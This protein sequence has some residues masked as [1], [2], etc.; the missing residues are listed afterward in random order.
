MSAVMSDLQQTARSMR[1]GRG[2]LA[3]AVVTMALGITAATLMF[4]LVS[5]VLL[6]PLPFRDPDKLVMVWTHLPQLPLGFDAYPVHGRQYRALREGSTGQLSGIDAFKA[7]LFNLSTKD[8]RVERIDGLVT[9]AGLFDTLGVHP[10]AGRF[11]QAGEDAP[12]GGHVAVIGFG[13]WARAFGA[14]PAAIGSVVRLNDE[15]FTIVGVA[16][17]GFDFPRGGEM[18]GN[19]QFPARTELWVAARPPETGPAEH[20][21]V[22]RMRTGVS[23]PQA[24][25]A[26]NAATRALEA[27]MPGARGWFGVQVVPMARQ[28]VPAIARTIVAMLFAAATI[29]VLIGCANAAQLLV[30]RGLRRR[31]ELVIRV[32]LGASRARLAREALL[33]S[34]CLAATAASIALVLTSFGVRLIKTLGPARFPRLA[35]LA[36][37]WRVI[38][39]AALCAVTVAAATALWPAVIV[40]RA[41]TEAMLRK[42]PRGGVGRGRAARQLVLAAQVA[43]SMVL[44]VASGLLMRSLERRV[45]VDPGFSADGVLTFEITLPPASYPEVSRGPVPA[46][47]PRVISAIDGVLAGLR[48]NPRI[49]WAGIGKPLPLSGAQ[50]VTVYVPEGVAAAA[51]GSAAD[52]RVHHRERRLVRSARRAARL[53]PSADRRRPRDI[54]AGRGRHARLRPAGL[55]HRRGRRQAGEAGRLRRF[56]GAVDD[57][58]RRGRRHEAL[59]PR[60]EAAA[61]DVRALYAGA[62]RVAGDR[63]VRGEGG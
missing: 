31:T 47:R 2:T 27:Q 25:A 37:D 30:V 29:L 5:T 35:E 46:I 44:L 43:L 39:F 50:E 13:L 54:A 26:L 23:V 49:A 48:A 34:F 60:G 12:G 45:A 58:R 10:A 51:A 53:R 6:R 63:A 19:F 14:D 11:F 40:T 38:L 61:D 3:A 59:R 56:T 8:G 41:S 15:A 18:P 33:E 52:D 22:A 36:I 55:E 57:H 28:T 20:A 4:G 21:V 32:A 17:R 1:H 42:T 9:T 7:D 24:E 62:V 16:P